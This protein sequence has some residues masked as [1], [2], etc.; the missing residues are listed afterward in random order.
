[1]TEIKKMLVFDMDGTIADLYNVD[2]WLIKLR[3]EDES[4]Y[5]EAK[6]L[7]DMEMLTELL[8]VLRD[9]GWSIAV[10][11]WLCMNGTKEYNAKVAAAKIAWLKKYNFPVDDLNIVEFGTMKNNCTINKADYQVLV[12]DDA[13]IRKMWTLGKAIQP[14]DL[15][16]FLIDTI[17]TEVFE[18]INKHA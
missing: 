3:A 17:E 10:T 14:K 2:K 16:K 6:P 11:S 12:D 9:L 8:N 4:P 7:F 5:T 1:M 15:I 13:N 18:K